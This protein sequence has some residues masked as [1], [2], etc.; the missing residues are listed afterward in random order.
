MVLYLTDDYPYSK[1]HYELCRHIVQESNISFTLYSVIRSG[2]N[3]RDLRSTYDKVNFDTIFYELKGSELRYKI[4]F[5]YKIHLKYRWLLE[6]VD[7]SQVKITHAATLFSEGAVV[8][9]LFKE[10]GIPY[11]VAVRGTDIELYFKYMF[12]LWHIGIEI[13]LNA[14]QI[15]CVTQNI[16][17]HL[18]D[19]SFLSHI[20]H[21]I[22]KKT[23][24]I[25]NGIDSYWLENQYVKKQ[26]PSIFH[27][28]YIGVFN[29]NKNVQRLIKVVLRLKK[30]YPNLQLT[31]IGGGGDCHDKILEYCRNYPETFTYLGKIYDKDKLCNIIR[32]H[33]IF[34]MISHSETFGLV[35]IEALS[36]GLPVLY[37][38]GQGIDGVF[39]EKVGE[40]VVSTDEHDIYKGLRKIIENYTSYQ[41]EKLGLHRF[42]W[43]N[44]AKS[45]ID[46]YSQII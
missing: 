46:I 45:Y 1:V 24:I 19:K 39:Q 43:Q 26:V 16:Y 30:I 37:T 22:R 10:K 9:K 20:K 42:S 6:H 17:E 25:S 32:E 40:A 5:F 3:V 7:I 4:D 34:T 35:Y 21:V 31:L 28:L 18:L 13:L 2:I 36:Q 41:I 27:L 33:D 38:K 29:K 8:L 14:S 23:I 12:H 15:I 11:V 44:I